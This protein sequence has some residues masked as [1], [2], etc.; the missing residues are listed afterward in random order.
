MTSKL[1]KRFFNTFG[2][3]PDTS[4]TA[5]FIGHYNEYPQITPQRLLELVVLASDSDDLKVFKD[6]DDLKNTVLNILIDCYNNFLECDYK[7]LDEWAIEIKDKV[8]E[9]FEVEQ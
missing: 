4:E 8:L 9:I 6:V 7:N 1:E 5:Y 2:I 3:K